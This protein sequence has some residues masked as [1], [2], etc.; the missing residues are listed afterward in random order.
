MNVSAKDLGTGKEQSIKIT[1]KSGLSE[2]EID[3]MVKDAEVHAEE[4]KKKREQITLK[5]NLDS[6]VYTTEKLIKD[7]DKDLPEDEKKKAEEAIAEAKKALEGDDLDA[8]KAAN[9]RLTNASHALSNVLYQKQSQ[10][11]GAADGAGAEGSAEGEA[12]AGGSDK[13]DDDVID[14]DYKDVN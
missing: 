6:M 8:M 3:K 4:D 10:A 7:N 11:G 1:A 12:A 14:A 5:N 9:E 13:K 2:E